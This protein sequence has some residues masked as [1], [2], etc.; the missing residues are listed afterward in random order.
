MRHAVPEDCFALKGGRAINLFVRDLPRLSVDIHIAFLPVADRASSFCSIHESMCRISAA[1]TDALKSISARNRAPNPEMPVSKLFVSD[2]ASARIKVEVSTVLRGCVFPPEEMQTLPR[3]T[4]EFGSLL[5][6]V[7]SVPDLH[8]GKLAA[9]LNRQPPRDFF[10]VHI[11]F[12]EGGGIDSRI[13]EAFIVYLIS[14][15]RPMHEVLS[16][17]RKELPQEV[18][19]EF[20]GMSMESVN[21][22]VLLLAKE[23]LVLKSPAVCRTGTGSSCRPWYRAPRIGNSLRRS[24]QERSRRWAGGGETSTCSRQNDV[25]NWLPDS[26]RCSATIEQKQFQLSVEDSRF[27]QAV[28]TSR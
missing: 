5:M 27:R 6:R 7:P 12:G 4:A 8:A 15:N 2:R 21:P 17:S 25:R 24:T 26:R 3:A 1:I 16:R 9:A 13:R 10:D 19:D 20:I 22:S 23:R 18:L 28:I 11:L 14:H